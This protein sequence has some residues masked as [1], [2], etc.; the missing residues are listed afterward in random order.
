MVTGRPRFLS[1]LLNRFRPFSKIHRLPCSL[2]KSITPEVPT[3]SIRR[4][5]SV[6]STCTPPSILVITRHTCRHCSFP[7]ILSSLKKSNHKIQLTLR[8]THFG[9]LKRW[10]GNFLC[11]KMK[12][13]ANCG[14]R[15][16]V[17]DWHGLIGISR[18]VWCDQ[19]FHSSVGI[20]PNF[21]SRSTQKDWILHCH[22]ILSMLFV[23]RRSQVADIFMSVVGLH[24]YSHRPC[25]S[26]RPFWSGMP[27]FPVLWGKG[28]PIQN[29]T[30]WLT[31]ALVCLFELGQ[32]CSGQLLFIISL[33]LPFWGPY[34]PR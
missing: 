17:K 15:N 7:C 32:P 21:P 29:L 18:L 3:R 16:L 6:C 5:C 33:F 23:F 30:I 20:S 13:E 27:Y 31:Y 26:P 22:I 2:P 24:L 12:K 34:Q 28:P 25:H 14:W 1:P 19:I 4:H 10:S 11:W 9:C 8:Q